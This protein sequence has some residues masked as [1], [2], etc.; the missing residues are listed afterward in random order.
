MNSVNSM[1]VVKNM[2]CS[3]GGR[4]VFGT[5]RVDERGQITLPTEARGVFGLQAGEDLLVLGDETKGIALVR[6]GTLR[7]RA[8]EMLDLAGRIPVEEGE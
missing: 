5:V 7:R 3:C 2:M 6:A 8:R 1:K 4:H